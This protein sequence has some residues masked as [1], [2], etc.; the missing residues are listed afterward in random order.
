M[1]GLAVQRLS[2]QEELAMENPVVLLVLTL[3]NPHFLERIQRRQNRPAATSRWSDYVL[4]SE[5]KQMS[6]HTRS[7]LSECAPVA[8]KSVRKAH[9]SV[10]GTEEELVAGEHRP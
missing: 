8:R 5:Q 10:S 2:L 1:A 9:I 3:G 4:E 6:S 7:M